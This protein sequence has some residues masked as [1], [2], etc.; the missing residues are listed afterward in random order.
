LKI[1]ENAF[2]RSTRNKKSLSRYSTNEF[3]LLIDGGEAE[4][5]EDAK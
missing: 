5:Y 3:F 4:F 2:R 1:L